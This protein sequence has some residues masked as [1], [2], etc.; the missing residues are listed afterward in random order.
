MSAPWNWATASAKRLPV[1]PRCAAR[2][3]LSEHAACHPRTG[4]SHA[5]AG[6]PCG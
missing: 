3:A 2:H 6:A 5:S 4:S 1:A